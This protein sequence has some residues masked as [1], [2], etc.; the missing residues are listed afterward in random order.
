M[1]QRFPRAALEVGVAEA[2]AEAQPEWQAPLILG[3]GVEA[4]GT[5]EGQAQQ[6]AQA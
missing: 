1:A 5:P 3:A 2:I 4:V 6:A